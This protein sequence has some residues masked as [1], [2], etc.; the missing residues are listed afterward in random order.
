MALKVL[1]GCTLLERER[2]QMNCEG[3]VF[4]AP[5]LAHF[6]CRKAHNSISSRGRYEGIALQGFG[7]FTH[8]HIRAQLGWF[9]SVYFVFGLSHP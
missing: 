3:M 8:Y 2:I 7:V 4:S 1:A 6:G 9:L 5:G